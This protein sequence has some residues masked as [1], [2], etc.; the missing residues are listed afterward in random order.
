[1]AF[2]KGSPESAYGFAAPAAST[3]EEVYEGLRTGNGNM[4]HDLVPLLRDMVRRL[5]ELEAENKR[6]KQQ[7]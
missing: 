3:L 6:L 1:M 2:G 5:D 7:D 4:M